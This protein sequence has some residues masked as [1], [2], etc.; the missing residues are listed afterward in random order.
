MSRI[1][2]VPTGLQDLLGSKT[3][4]RN[5]SDL[6]EEVRPTLGLDDLLVAERLSY[7]RATL[8]VTTRGDSADMLVPVGELWLL[9]SL[10]IQWNT[11]TAGIEYNLSV[12]IVDMQN[13]VSFAPGQPMTLFATGD[14]VAKTVGSEARFAVTFPQNHI[15]FGDNRLRIE[16]DELSA[17]GG[18]E[19]AEFAAEYVKL[20][21]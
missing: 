3:F 21:V 15:L 9:R 10:Y 13:T 20:L 16:V 5:P 14:Q 11:A 19:F 12:G 1:T 6:L 2:R 17:A 8:T 18:P 7:K 4:G